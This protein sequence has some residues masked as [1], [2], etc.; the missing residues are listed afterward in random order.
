MNRLRSKH[1]HG[2]RNGVRRLRRLRHTRLQHMA[3][4]SSITIETQH[5]RGVEK[6]VYEALIY[7]TIS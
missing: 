6:E 7:G 3:V 2:K 5:T 1:A 4:A